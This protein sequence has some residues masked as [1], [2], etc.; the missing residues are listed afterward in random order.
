M[1]KITLHCSWIDKLLIG[2][3]TRLGLGIEENKKTFSW[4]KSKVFYHILFVRN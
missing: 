1:R 4:S 3:H 2:T